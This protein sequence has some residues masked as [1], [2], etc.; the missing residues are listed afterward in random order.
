MNQDETDRIFRL[1]AILFGDADG[2][3]EDKA[4]ELF[5]ADAVAYVH[6]LSADGEYWSAWGIDDFIVQYLTRNGFRHAA[7]QHNLE[8]LRDGAKENAASSVTSTES[9]RAEQTLTG[10]VSASS[11]IENEEVCQV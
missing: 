2:V 8:L 10:P 9:G 7:S 5:G 11:L 6:K 1:E 3:L 4:E